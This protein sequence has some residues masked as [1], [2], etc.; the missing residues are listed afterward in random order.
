MVTVAETIAQ[1]QHACGHRDGDPRG[2]FRTLAQST[3]KAFSILRCS[4]PFSPA[5]QTQRWDFSS[6]HQKRQN[7]REE[8]GLLPFPVN[9]PIPHAFLFLHPQVMFYFGIER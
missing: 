8:A 6:P 7:T 5:R 1:A 9:R 4:L 2:F 3:H